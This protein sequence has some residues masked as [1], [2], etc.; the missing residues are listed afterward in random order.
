M[1]RFV[2]RGGRLRSDESAPID[3]EMRAP[4]RVASPTAIRTASRPPA[5]MT[6]SERCSDSSNETAGSAKE[7][8]QPVDFERANAKYARTPSTVVSRIQPSGADLMAA[9]SPGGAGAPTAVE[10]LRVRAMATP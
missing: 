5:P 6:H 2:E 8:V 4:T 3:P 7:T 9:S 10:G 1:Q